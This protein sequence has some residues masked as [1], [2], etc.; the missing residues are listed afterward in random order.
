MNRRHNIQLDRI[1]SIEKEK[2]LW[3]KFF[4]FEKPRPQFKL[5]ENGEK[6]LKLKKMMWGDV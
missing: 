6:E 1:P 4:K 3:K 2:T 5:D